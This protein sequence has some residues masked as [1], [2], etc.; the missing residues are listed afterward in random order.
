LSSTVA[1]TGASTFFAGAWLDSSGHKPN[2]RAD[3]MGR[4]N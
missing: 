4:L 2:D 3:S 1:A